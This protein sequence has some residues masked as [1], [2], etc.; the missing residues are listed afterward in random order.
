L[1]FE[2]PPGEFNY[3][4]QMVVDEMSGVLELTV[5]LK[6]D[7]KSGDNWADCQAWN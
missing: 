7:L 3:V 1:V 4:A 2:V 5:P 6:V